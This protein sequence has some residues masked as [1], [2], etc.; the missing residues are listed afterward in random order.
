MHL[1]YRLAAPLLFVLGLAACQAPASDFTDQDASAVRAP[2]DTYVSAALAADWDTWGNTLS[3]D[4]IFFPPNQAP[5]VGH[6]AVMA[7]VREFPTMTSFT[8]APDEVWGTG[9]LAFAHGTYSYT[10][11]LPDGSAITEQGTYVNI[12]RLQADG[13]WRYTHNIWHSNLPAPA[14]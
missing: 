12:F 3:A 14:P 4:V 1:S 8:A 7:W 10:A 5:L 6:D 2:I 11:T 9:D 13:S